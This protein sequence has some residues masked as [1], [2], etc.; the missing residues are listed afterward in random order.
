M[1]A[2]ARLWHRSPCQMFPKHPQ[3]LPAEVG[4]TALCPAYISNAGQ[5]A[6]LVSLEVIINHFSCVSLVFFPTRTPNAH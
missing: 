3:L 2:A 1:T 4:A 6:L 5:P